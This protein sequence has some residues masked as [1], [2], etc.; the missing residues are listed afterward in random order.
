[1]PRAAKGGNMPVFTAPDGSQ[2]IINSATVVRVRKTLHGE[3]DDANSRI[4]STRLNLVREQPADAAAA[5]AAELPSLVQLT[6]GQNTPIWVNANKVEGPFPPRAERIEDGY[7]SHI[8]V[9]NR[10]QHVMESEE[11]VRELFAA[12]K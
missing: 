1:M 9:L 11:E 3:A 10:L 4:D 8:V 12:V 6:G 5:I 7:R 2:V